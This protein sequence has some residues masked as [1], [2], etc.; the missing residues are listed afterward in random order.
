MPGGKFGI[1]SF[2]PCYKWNTF[3]TKWDTL[4]G[5]P[6][7]SFKPCYKWNTFNTIEGSEYKEEVFVSFKPCYKW[8][9]FNTKSIVS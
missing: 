9:T 4:I 3:N 8:N 1:T 6:L 7:G 5:Q 2:K